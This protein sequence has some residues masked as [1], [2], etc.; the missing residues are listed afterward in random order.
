MQD[1]GLHGEYLCWLGLGANIG[2]PERNLAN[3][4]ARLRKTHA[5]E[6]LKVSPLYRT[7]PWGKIDQD[8]FYNCCVGLRCHASP[9]EIL[10]ICLS[11]EQDMKRVRHERWG[12]RNIDIDLLAVEDCSGRAILSEEPELLLPHPRMTERGFVIKP[13]ADIAPD[14][15]VKG[16]R[17]ANWL[18]LVNTDGIE[19]IAK[20]DIWWR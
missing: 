20:T 11:I 12:P 2:D 3:A 14:L 4:V 1:I 6:L 7:P 9:K 15:F 17:I 16:R 13:L 10:H 18:E 8:W 5:F 19:Q